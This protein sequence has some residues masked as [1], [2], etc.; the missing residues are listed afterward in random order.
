MFKL[1][2]PRQLCERMLTALNK[3]A[4]VW[5]LGG[6]WCAVLQYFFMFCGECFTSIGTNSESTG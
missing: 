1:A 4:G 2:R 5:A 3:K 6:F